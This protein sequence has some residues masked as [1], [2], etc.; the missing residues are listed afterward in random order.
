MKKTLATLL[1]LGLVLAGSC[2]LALDRTSPSRYVVQKGDTLWSV[3]DRFLGEP[4]HWPHIWQANPQ[5]QNPHLIYPG[6]VLRMSTDD[7][8]SVVVEPGPRDEAPVPAIALAEIEPFLK[9]LRVLQTLDGLPR[10]VGVEDGKLRAGPG[11]RIYANGS[12]DLRHGGLYDVLRPSLRYGVDRHGQS[13]AEDIDPEGRVAGT[14]ALDMDKGFSSGHVHRS[15]GVRFLGYEL[16]RVQ[17]ARL[18]RAKNGNEAAVL[19]LEPGG[20]EVKAGDILVPSAAPAYY[21]AS[22]YP[23]PPASSVLGKRVIGVVDGEAFGGPRDVIAINAGVDAGVDNGTVFSIRSPGSASD[24]DPST[25]VPGE[26]AGHAM[27]FRTFQGISY[28]LVMDGI[29]SVHVQDALEDPDL[30]L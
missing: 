3:A 9:D 13:Y 19:T 16:R 28:A 27:V 7:A 6:D 4:W 26:F 22:Y 11:Q 18:L 21:D 25:R 5:I 15:R 12:L 24:F 14:F 20:M 23:H 2:A 17:T 29:K 30:H 10:V 1:A 8:S